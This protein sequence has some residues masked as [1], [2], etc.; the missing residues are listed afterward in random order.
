MCRGGLQRQ[1][2]ANTP[3]VNASRPR[4]RQAAAHLAAV[5]AATGDEAHAAKDAGDGDL[6][7]DL[8]GDPAFH[9]H[10]PLQAG[11]RRRAH[12]ARAGATPSGGL[13]RSSPRSC[14]APGSGGSSPGFRS[15]SP[16][17]RGAIRPDRR[18]GRPRLA[19]P[20][21]PQRP[22][23]RRRPSSPPAALRYPSS[24]SG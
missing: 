12:S 21:G 11:L 6:P 8:P 5:L 15:A 14:R 20:V 22:E 7:G 9:R 13:H 4:L 24:L 10:C 16:P 17:I 23:R 2:P 18:A 3:S 1:S 19:A